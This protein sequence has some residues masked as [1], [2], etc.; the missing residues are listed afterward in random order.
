MTKVV[1]EK[2]MEAIASRFFAIIAGFYTSTI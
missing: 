2:D 1:G